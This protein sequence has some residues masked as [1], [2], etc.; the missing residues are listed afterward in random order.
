MQIYP[1]IF[2]VFF[3]A[4]LIRPLY[5]AYFEHLE[6]FA[7]HQTPK[8]QWY[9]NDEKKL[10]TLVQTYFKQATT[11][12]KPNVQAIIVPHG[13]YRTS[14]LNAAHGFKYAS[15]RAYKHI[16]ILGPLHNNILVDGIII[17]NAGY[18]STPMH[19]SKLNYPLIQKLQGH[20]LIYARNQPF[21]HEKSI[22]N[23]MPFVQA[24]FPDATLLPVLTGDLNP[25]QL[26]EI[27]NV[28]KLFIDEDTL[29]IVSTD[30]SHYGRRHKWRPFTKNIEYQIEKLDLHVA[31]LLTTLDIEGLTAFTKKFNPTICGI[32]PLV[33]LMKLLPPPTLAKTL[34][35]SISGTMKKNF[36]TSSISYLSM[37]FK[38][39]W[40]VPPNS[41]SLHR[42]DKLTPEQKNN[43]LA[44]ARQALKSYIL[45]KKRV[46]PTAL[47]VP[48]TGIYAEK[49]AVF[50][51]LHQDAQVR[52]SRGDLK[53]SQSLA[54]V[55]IDQTIDAA[56]RDRR[57]APLTPN[58]LKD[59]FIEIT[60]V[61]PPTRIKD[62]SEIVLGKHG[63]VMEKY[64]R[65]AVFLP[66]DSIDKN[67][68]LK[69]TL[70]YLSMKTGLDADDW[71][72]EANLSIFTVTVF[73]DED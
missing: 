11:R 58:D 1:Q 30:F 41:I 20:D 31:Q 55:I 64:G 42:T 33:L 16:I 2:L 62:S 38:G 8:S 56:V 12:R 51:S 61:D 49:H 36:T 4:T 14:R 18:Y 17:P 24:A 50:V 57:F 73:D 52:G 63:M 13:G 59:I 68:S 47:K 65:E 15:G 5:G 54:Q 71:K 32:I 19:T 25:D 23:I 21:Y 44:L 39:K 60:L 48:L 35:Y 45:K 28:F 72:K 27:A 26:N 43:L 70:D 46:K 40:H 6:H 29:V 9:P 66:Q 7:I 69:E 10:K 37:A 22:N 3:V 53:P 67:W 34:K